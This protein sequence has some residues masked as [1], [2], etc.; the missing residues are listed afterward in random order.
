[1]RLAGTCSRYSNSAMP[2]LTS[3]ATYQAFPLRFLRWA[4]HANVM[5][6]F[7]ATSSRIAVGITGN[8]D[9][10]AASLPVERRRQPDAERPQLQPR[11]V[12]AVV[13]YRIP[14]AGAGTDDV[15]RQVVD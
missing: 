12:R 6:T 11:R 15:L 9:G 10:T 13:V 5:K 8:A 1:M 3:A 2:Q 7:E 4:Y 14:P